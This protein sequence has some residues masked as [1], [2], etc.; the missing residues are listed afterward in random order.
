M[1]H[2]YWFVRRDSDTGVV[3]QIPVSHHA[4]Y[5]VQE[6]EWQPSPLKVVDTAHTIVR[7]PVRRLWRMPATS[8]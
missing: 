8:H 7:K 6:E 3:E 1:K 4:L 2:E 5:R